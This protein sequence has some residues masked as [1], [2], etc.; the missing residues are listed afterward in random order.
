MAALSECTSC[1]RHTAAAERQR[2]E[3]RRAEAKK[4][5]K[6]IGFKATEE[7]E[8]GAVRDGRGRAFGP[9]APQHHLRRC[10]PSLA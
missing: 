8:K 6:R 1:I 10:R 3:N 7:K 2:E 5:T 9:R 4:R